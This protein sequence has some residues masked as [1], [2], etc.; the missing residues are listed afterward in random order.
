MR[1]SIH[2][3]ILLCAV[4]IL[5]GCESRTAEDSAAAQISDSAGFAEQQREVE[6]TVA[7][8]GS[9]M[10]SVSLLAPANAVE[11]DLRDAYGD[12]VTVELLNGWIAR[13]DS[14]PGRRAS[15]PWPD[16]IDIETVRQLS[17]NLVEVSGVVVYVTSV[18]RSR[19]GNAITR[20]VRLRVARMPDG[21]WRISEYQESA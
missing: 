3:T 12:V 7:R 8:L 19:Q 21:S 13:P 18:E 6:E 15:S 10:Q 16:R 4:S 14:A 2:V 20:A 9:R 11:Q 17:S 1:N 5:A